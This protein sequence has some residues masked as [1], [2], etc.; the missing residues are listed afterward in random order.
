M[1]F[2]NQF[3][4]LVICNMKQFDEFLN[5]LFFYGVIFDIYF[6]QLK[7]VIREV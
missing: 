1:S 2:Y 6:G 7:G 3:I 4:L 5:S